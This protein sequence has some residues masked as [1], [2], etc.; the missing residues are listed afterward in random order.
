MRCPGLCTKSNFTRRCFCNDVRRRT[1]SDVEETMCGR[2]PVALFYSA[3]FLNQ[4][5]SGATV[6]TIQ[7][8]FVNICFDYGTVD[9]H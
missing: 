6:G 3:S 5:P 1:L 4:S 8:C 2:Y 9:R 7:R